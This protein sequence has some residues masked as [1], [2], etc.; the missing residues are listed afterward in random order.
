MGDLTDDRTLTLPVPIVDTWFHIV[1]LG[2]LDADDTH[3]LKILTATQGSEFFNGGITWNNTVANDNDDA[4]S[5]LAFNSIV[6]GNGSSND[7]IDIRLAAGADIWLHAKSTTVWYVWG[8][9]TGL[10]IPTIGDSV[11]G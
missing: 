1:Y 9:V 7:G 8:T 2:E 10:T 3:D 6:N 11:T 5:D 4:S